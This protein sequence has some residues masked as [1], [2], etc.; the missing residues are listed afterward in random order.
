MDVK[1]IIMEDQD[2]QVLL[3]LARQS[4]KAEL[5][6]KSPEIHPK[7]ISPTL[8]QKQA[9]FVTLTAEQKLRGCIGH[10]DPIQELYKDVTE[11]ARAAAFQ[12]PRFMPLTLE[13]FKRIAIEISV[14]SKSETL[15]YDSLSSLIKHLAENKPGVVLKQG[16][17][18]ATFLPQVWGEVKGAREFLTH[19]SI[20]AGLAPDEWTR[21]AEIETYT[22]EKISEE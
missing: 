15:E 3:N 9:S 14:L 1:Q 13:E 21:D 8:T 22:V 5:E 7:E 10:L 6:K 20:K 12:D 2:Q 18:K 17:R 4:I 11:N 16:I 19:L